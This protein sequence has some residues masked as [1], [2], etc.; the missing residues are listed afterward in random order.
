MAEV[1]VQQ[2][3]PGQAA[4]DGAS[5]VQALPLIEKGPRGLCLIHAWVPELGQVA[6]QGPGLLEGRVSWRSGLD[7]WG[8][9]VGWDEAGAFSPR[10]LGGS[11]QEQPPLCPGRRKK[12]APGE[13][14]RPNR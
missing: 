6:L 4:W 14:A 9:G 2:G 3:S 10:R 1:M 12:R 5:G 11:G 7:G 8:Q 13:G